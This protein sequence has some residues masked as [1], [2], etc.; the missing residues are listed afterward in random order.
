MDI[1][2]Y[3]ISLN[4][5]ILQNR[6]FQF[7]KEAICFCGNKKIFKMEDIYN[8]IAKK[9]NSRRDAVEIAMRR[10]I[11]KIDYKTLSKDKTTKRVK[12]NKEVLTLILDAQRKENKENDL[13]N[14][15]NK[16]KLKKI[17]GLENGDDDSENGILEYI[18]IIIS[19]CNRLENI[20]DKKIQIEYEKVFNK[21][22]KSVKDK[23]Q[24]IIDG[25][26]GYRYVEIG[27]LERLLEKE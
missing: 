16:D 10:C 18:E 1:E 21:G 8:H 26:K 5:D 23:I 13:D 7:W 14:Y 9:Y 24:T 20:E 3:L 27:A 22:V 17:L 6:G 15:I 11:N 19:E 12:T 2:K 4:F 25:A